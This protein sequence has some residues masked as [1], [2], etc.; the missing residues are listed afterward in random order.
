MLVKTILNLLLITAIF[1]YPWI[2]F[3]FR[4]VMI[5]LINVGWFIYCPWPIFVPVFL[6]ITVV[7][8][9]C[10]ICWQI[11]LLFFCVCINSS[12]SFSLINSFPW[13][14]F[15]CISLLSLSLSLLGSAFLNCT[16]LSK[17][18]MDVTVFLFPGLFILLIIHLSWLVFLVSI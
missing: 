12:F 1:W 9:F 15:M 13:L 2:H 17:L 11:H 6:L 10:C 18:L 14:G 8:F 5:P 16:P 4:L 7:V 3:S